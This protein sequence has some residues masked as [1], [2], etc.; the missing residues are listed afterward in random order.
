MEGLP[1]GQHVPEPLPEAR[2]RHQVVPLHVEQEEAGALLGDGS[3]RSLV[4]LH[5]PGSLANVG[6]FC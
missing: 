5:V 3:P 6:P 2:G 1:G 4:E